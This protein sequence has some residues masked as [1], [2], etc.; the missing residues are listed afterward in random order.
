MACR[1]EEKV[2]AAQAHAQSHPWPLL[3]PRPGPVCCHCSLLL[4]VSH[5]PEDLRALVPPMDPKAVETAQEAGLR[6]RM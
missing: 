2:L 3:E 6:S 1:D 5:L 4:Q